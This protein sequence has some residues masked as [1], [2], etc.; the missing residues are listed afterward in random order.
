MD[1]RKYVCK[2]CGCVIEYFTDIVAKSKQP[3]P[4]QCYKCGGKRFERRNDKS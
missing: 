2:K 3:V 4:K 1:S